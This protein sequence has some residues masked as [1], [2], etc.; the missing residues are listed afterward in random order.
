MCRSLFIF[1]LLLIGGA[2]ANA[3]TIEL[4]VYG[5]VCGFCAQGIEKTLRK[6]PAVEDV[7]VSL[8]NKLV[9]VML[10][11]GQDLSDADVQKALQDAGYTVKAIN[12]T[13]RSL[14]E[15]RSG[16]TKKP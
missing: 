14:A 1:C 5:L 4:K 7:V 8:E 9:A 12:R 2:N 11:L 13:D 15:I 10:R 3:A 16:L 6:N